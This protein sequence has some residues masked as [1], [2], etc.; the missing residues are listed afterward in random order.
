ME[1][2]S[3]Q[4]IVDEDNNQDAIVD[5]N[6]GELESQC[7]NNEPPL[8]ATPV[9]ANDDDDIPQ[10]PASKRPRKNQIST[11]THGG[12]HPA[13]SSKRKLQFTTDDVV[14][15][16][17]DQPSSLGKKH[18]ETLHFSKTF[19]SHSFTTTTT[20]TTTIIDRYDVKP[21]FFFVE[22][23]LQKARGVQEQ[24]QP[25]L[26]KI[27]REDV[28]KSVDHIKTAKQQDKTKPKYNLVCIGSTKD[29]KNRMILSE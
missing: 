21:S 25:L 24:Q 28:F 22:N 20:T 16:E 14:G 7:D 10:P 6:G 9:R 4:A 26:S 23:L 5:G 12:K 18:N 13:S 29:Q 3:S 19:F 27:R 8:T 15:E 11:G 17:D 1:S 2:L